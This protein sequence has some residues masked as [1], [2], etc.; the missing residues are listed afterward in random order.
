MFARRSEDNGDCYQ[1][2]FPGWTVQV[3]LHLPLQ[4][5]S[6]HIAS[7]MLPGYF[8]PIWTRVHVQ[9]LRGRG[10]YWRHDKSNKNHRGQMNSD[11]T[12]H[13]TTHPRAYCGFGSAERQTWAS[14][15]HRGKSRSRTG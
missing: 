8:Q 5:V 15:A 11:T 14:E 6:R 10:L 12:P 13:P 2:F 9:L 4:A 1:C 3:P 7:W